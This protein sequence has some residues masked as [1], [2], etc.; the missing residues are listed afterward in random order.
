M[1][2]LFGGKERKY[3]TSLNATA[4]VL[5]CVLE[6][7]SLKAGVPVVWTILTAPLCIRY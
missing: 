6:R 5:L 3:K 7:K 2:L 4:T 1:G